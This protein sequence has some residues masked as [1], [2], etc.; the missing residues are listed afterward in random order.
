[1]APKEGQQTWRLNW[2]VKLFKE[3]GQIEDL[4]ITFH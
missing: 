1:M 3:V 4:V 2:K